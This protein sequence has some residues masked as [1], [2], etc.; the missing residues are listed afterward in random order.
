M[1]RTLRVF[2]QAAPLV[3]CLLLAR[4]IHALP[5]PTVETPLPPVETTG[6]QV[7]GKVLASG[8]RAWF[9]V[10]YAQAPLRELRWKPPQPIHWSGVYNADRFAPECFQELRGSNIN[11]YFGNEA[12]SEDC[13][14]L[15]IWAPAD[16][17]EGERPVIVWIYGGGLRIGSAS[18][19]N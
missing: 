7:A 13:L 4:S 2:V 17:A 15:N 10:P 5:L 19:R 18:M 1:N 8:V 16:T 14:Y 11:H 3:A 9:G 6:G 12:I